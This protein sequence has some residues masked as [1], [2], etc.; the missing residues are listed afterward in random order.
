MRRL[1]DLAESAAAKLQD[2]QLALIEAGDLTVTESEVLRRDAAAGIFAKIEFHWR[3]SDRLILEQIRAAADA[4]FDDQF[5]A[6]ITV[7]DRFYQSLRAPQVNAH[8]V[9]VSGSDGRPVWQQDSDGKPVEDWGRLTGQDIETALFDLQEIRLTV[10]QQV[11]ELRSEA[12]Y[13]K[14]V[15]DDGYQDGYRGLV[16]GTQGDRN[17]H[18]SK[19][20][21][22]DKYHSFFRYYVY[23]RSNTFWQELNAFIRLLER[24]RDWRVRE[25]RR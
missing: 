18:A 12:I 19:V 15:Y 4:M 8:G 14:H 24:V 16:E 23:S 3:T 20:S 25:Q 17:A 11:D 10:S 2:E 1:G 6:A 7:L 13:A 22:T 5:D 9:V 21:R